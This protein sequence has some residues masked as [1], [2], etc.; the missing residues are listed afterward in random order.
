MIINKNIL[1][2]VVFISDS[3]QDALLK[4]NKNKHKIVYAV[5]EKNRLIGS[6][7]DGDVRRWILSTSEFDLNSGL[8]NII[9]QPCFSMRIDSDSSLIESAFNERITSIPLIDQYGHLVAVAEPKKNFIEIGGCRI[10]NEDPVFIIAE[11]GNNHQGNIKLAK[12]LIDLAVRAN[13]DCVKFQMRNMSKLYRNK[14]ISNDASADLGAQYTLDLLSKF[15]L[16]DDELFEVF[17]Y[18][19]SK[20]VIPLCTP[21]DLESLKKLEEYGMPAYKV[22][23]ADFTNYELLGALAK[24]GK[25][26]ICSTGMSTETEIQSSVAFLKRKNA[27]FILLHCNSTYPTPFKDVR[28]NYLTRLRATSGGIVGYSGHE[29]GWSVPVAA[30]ALGAKVIEKHITL[31]KSLEGT[32]HKVSLLPEEFQQ[33]VVQIKQVEQSLGDSDV[34]EITQGELMNREVLAKSLMINRD[35]SEGEIITKEM[36]E[37]IS[38][39]QGLQP[40][41]MDELI[42]KKAN[43]N[44]VKGD[45][46]FET[47]IK[48]QFQKKSKYLFNRPYGIPVRYHDYVALTKDVKLDFVEFHLSYK[49]L[50][51]DL[52][53]FIET[54][55]KIGFAVH[56]PELFS[57]DHILDLSSYD[58]EYR[59][60]SINELQR[61]IEQTIKLKDYFPDTNKPVIVVNAGG[62][63]ADGFLSKESKDR[64]YRLVKES[65]EK[66]DM[67]GVEVAIQT[68]PPFPW[69][70][71]GQSYHNLFLDPDEIKAF[72]E[73]SGL[74]ICLDVSHSMMTCNYYNWDLYEFIRT[75]GPYV[76]HMH[77]VDAKGADGEGIQIGEGDVDFDRLA[78]VLS[79][80]APRIQFIPEVWQGHNNSGEGFWSALSFLEMK[81]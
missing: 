58:D 15:Q 31:D 7:S 18:C 55:Q 65:F 59:T 3:L 73:E 32:D 54:G 40:N 57:G 77:I 75:I 63:N 46:F 62:W 21:W 61:V 9:H 47:D 35:L 74:K 25:P 36:I 69:H 17:D 42:G 44:F 76:V 20:G 29:R 41:R 53:E 24:T 66:L 27:Q 51:V 19:K 72:C 14:G 38:P 52:D 56:A 70:F 22:A 64:K 13:V 34:R 23:S 2:F 11:V 1:E 45:F 30:V 16:N 12:D 4:I 6:M 39:G 80:V 68:M 79:E 5:D 71:G 28:L 26:L 50:E 81:L 43:R 49:D 78:N 33:M 67:S 10:S 37:V 60:R 8:I 48:G